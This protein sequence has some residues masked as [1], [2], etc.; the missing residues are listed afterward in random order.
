[1]HAMRK[2]FLCGDLMPAR[3]VDQVL[4]FPIPKA[5]LREQCCSDAAEYVRLAQRKTNAAETLSGIPRRSFS[6]LAG[7]LKDA[8]TAREPLDAK[9]ANLESALTVSNA[10]W[11]HKAVCYRASPRNGIGLL[12]F[13]GIDIVTLANNHAM[14]F[15]VPG[16]LDSLDALDA[17]RIEH[18]GAGRNAREAFQGKL[19]PSREDTVVFGYCL[20][21]SGAP[22]SWRAG[23]S[24]P[25]VALLFSDDDVRRAAADIMSSSRSRLSTRPMTIVSLHCGSNWG[26]EIDPLIERVAR[27]FIEAGADIV[28]GHSSHHARE[29]EVYRKKLI[30]YGCGEVL[31]DYEGITDHP[32]FPA[33]EFRG[34]LRYAYFP[35]M[36]S[37]EDG[38][39]FARMEI[40]VFTQGDCFKIGAASGEETKGA[41][42]AL[43]PRYRSRGLLLTAKGPSTL[44]AEPMR[45]DGG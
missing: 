22:P 21:N 18:V 40:E 6:A 36:V 44:V 38:N 42:N 7:E 10:F 33:S 25:G 41:L 19:L 27:T 28:H 16:L 35:E 1:M 26:Y 15:G 11:P 9:L 3:G 29:A 24:R 43:A 2:F 31:N 8:I 30:L 4:P 34:N 13:L 20:E 17:S 12:R 45:G 39:A 5:A 14:D 37:E 23:E 32:A